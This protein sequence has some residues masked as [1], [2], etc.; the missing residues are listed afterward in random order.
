MLTHIEPDRGVLFDSDTAWG[1]VPL[2]VNFV[3]SSTLDVDDWVWDFGDGDSA[4]IQSPSHTYTQN[5]RF[6]VTLRATAGAETR[7]YVAV[8]YITAL[9]DSMC[10]A[11]VQGEAGS[12]VEV[13]I[14]ARNSIPLRR[15]VIPVEYSGTINL[16]LDSFSVAGCRTEYFDHISNIAL[17]PVNR[18][19]AYSIQ[20]VDAGTPDLESGYGPIIKLYFTIPPSATADQYADIALDGFYSYNPMFFGPVLDFTP[21]LETGRVGL[22]FLCGDSNR[23]GTC[24]IFDATY[25]ISYLYLGGPPPDP[26]ASGDVNNSGEINIFDV[27]HIVS[28]L[29]I[30]GPPP[31]CP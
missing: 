19:S 23:D 27:T 10:G 31:E 15:F 2:A 13:E 11:N 5:G 30:S 1:D 29:Y 8:N 12:S 22:P 24:N 17:D 16:H 28:Y 6:D 25:L 26:P 7:T 3:G 4:F 14:F 9:A 20:N 21:K 18:R